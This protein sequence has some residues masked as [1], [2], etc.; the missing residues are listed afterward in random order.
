MNIS[1]YGATGTVTGSKYLVDDGATHTLID[2]G[3]F[4]GFKQIRQRNWQPM[5]FALKPLKSVVLTH[6]HI[7]H[8]GYLPLLAK[9]G[10]SGPVYCSK[11]TRELCQIMLPDAAHLQEE[12]ARYANA[13]YAN[14]A[15]SLASARSSGMST[16]A[17]TAVCGR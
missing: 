13:K 12:E 16:H 3:L 10:F 4:Q 7:D 8:S 1:F 15:S 17:T 9:N 11:A 14:R 6:A 2:C 5:P